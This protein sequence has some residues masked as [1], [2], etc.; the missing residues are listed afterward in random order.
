[1]VVAAGRLSIGP[2]EEIKIEGGDIYYPTM[3]D[4]VKKTINARGR[5]APKAGSNV[6]REYLDKMPE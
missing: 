6:L 2:G 3:P 4:K 5:V 1:M